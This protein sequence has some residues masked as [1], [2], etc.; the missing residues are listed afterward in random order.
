MGDC[1]ATP[2]ERWGGCELFEK[3]LR[4]NFATLLSTEGGWRATD[5]QVEGGGMQ[6]RATVYVQSSASTAILAWT[7][8]FEAKGEND[9]V[10]LWRTDRVSPVESIPPC[11]PSLSSLIILPSPSPDGAV[12]GESDERTYLELRFALT[13]SGG[14]AHLALG[15]TSQA[16]D[17][18]GSAEKVS[19]AH[20][21]GAQK[22]ALLAASEQQFFASVEP[23]LLRAD[24]L[25]AIFRQQQQQEQEQKIQP[26]LPQQQGTHE[27]TPALHSDNATSTSGVSAD[28][29]E[30]SSPTK[31]GLRLAVAAFTEVLLQ[32]NRLRAAGA[33]RHQRLPLEEMNRVK[34][35]V[36]ALQSELKR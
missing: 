22:A 34:K 11:L 32:S 1:C 19:A 13:M 4:E 36:S 20:V 28:S 26:S 2:Q 30:S 35:L 25:L 16:L 29:S 17:A 33:S 7:M 21:E 24:T 31:E 9:S 10:L 6:N 3:V 15:H 12:A 5:C 8:V 27:A 23:Q 18:A 14:R